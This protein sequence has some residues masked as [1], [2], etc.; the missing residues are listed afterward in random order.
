VLPSR[1]AGALTAWGSAYLLG[2]VSLDDADDRTVGPDALHRVVGVVGED[3][4]V[5]VSIALG[6]LRARGV[7]ALRLVLPESGDPT[8]LPGPPS[9]TAAAV[10]AGSAVLTVGPL[11]V[12]SYALVA[13]VAG[14]RDG[15]VVR[16]DVVPV[17]RSVA[18]HGLPTLSEADRA[19]RE[20]MA[21][22]TAELAALDVARGRDDIAPRLAGLDREL[23]DVDL[24]P[25]LPAQ[26]QRLVATA[27]RLLGVLEIAAGT[28]GAAVTASEVRRRAEALRPLRTAARYALCAAY[29]A[30]A[31]NGA[32]S[33]GR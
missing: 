6:R 9:L 28:E 22:A 20:A 15:D 1:R 11:E 16:W 29:S 3:A 17:E 19:L 21:D 7:T 23:R 10:S 12:P 18:P 8:G 24:P 4:A 25:T 33:P 27:S 5:P 2:A 13:Q 32:P 14:A 30:A 31:E 26:A